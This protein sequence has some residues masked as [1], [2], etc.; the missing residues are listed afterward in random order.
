MFTG[1]FRNLGR[2]KNCSRFKSL[3]SL[4]LFLNMNVVLFFLSAHEC[5]S[6]NGKWV[7]SHLIY[8]TYANEKFGDD[9]KRSLLIYY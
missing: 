4:K 6:Y 8:V 9:I 3:F 2:Q 1:M 5:N 7:Y